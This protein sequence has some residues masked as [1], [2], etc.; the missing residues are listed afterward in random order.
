M[1]LTNR[2]QRIV[3]DGGITR[4]R[5][6]GGALAST[7]V[8]AGVPTPTSADPPNVQALSAEAIDRHLSS[9]HRDTLAQQ[10]DE[11]LT[12]DGWQRD[13]SG[14]IGHRSP[15]TSELGQ[16]DVVAIPYHH[17][18]HDEQAVLL[19]S[20]TPSLPTQVRQIDRVEDGHVRM[21]TTLVDG[22]G[23]LSRGHV[24]SPM[25]WWF[26]CSSVNWACVLSIAGAWA[27]SIAA[28]G[29]CML[30]PSRLTCLACIGAV[31]SATGATLGCSV[32]D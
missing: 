31:M 16:Y 21:R 18:Q 10:L 26:F 23:N 25:I 29:S 8:L 11:D 30:D 1:S 4:R 9:I 32:C 15:E 17:Q 7:A 19:W 20:D 27:G 6:L 2:T 13:L 12:S 22:D 28:C 24:T 5:M 3:T 14:I